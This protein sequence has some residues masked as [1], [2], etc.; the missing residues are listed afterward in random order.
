MGRCCR[1]GIDVAPFSQE[2]MKQPGGISPGF[3]CPIDHTHMTSMVT[4][5]IGWMQIRVRDDVWQ[6]SRLEHLCQLFQGVHCRV[7][8]G[9]MRPPVGA[10]STRRSTSTASRMQVL[11]L[12]GTYPTS[13]LGRIKGLLSQ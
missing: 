4:E 1:G 11:G 5:Q 12:K 8:R 3:F 7:N 13:V 9:L 10:K 6:C 2:L